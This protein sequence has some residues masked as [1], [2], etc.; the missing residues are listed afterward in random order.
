VRLGA[1]VLLNAPVVHLI[2]AINGNP[3]NS[4]FLD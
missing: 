3:L 2:W 4:G 1:T